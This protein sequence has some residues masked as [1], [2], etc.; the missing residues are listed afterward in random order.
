MRCCGPAGK[1]GEFMFMAVEARDG[2]GKA[3]TKVRQGE[4]GLGEAGHGLAGQGPR[5]GEAWLG[6]AGQGRARIMGL[7]DC[8]LAK[9]KKQGR[10]NMQTYDVRLEGITPLLMHSDDIQWAD[11][12][13]AWRMEPENKKSGT[14]GDDRSPAWRWIGALYED[15][16]KV[17]IPSDNLMTMLREGGAKCPTGKGKTT[18]KAITQTGLVVDQ[19]AWPIEVRGEHV[20]YAPIKAMIGEPLFEEH[21]KLAHDL[22][23]FLF[24][25]RA[26][27][28][29]SKHIRVR[30][31]FDQW[32][33]AGT[34]TVTDGQITERMLTSILTTAGAHVGIGDWR[35]SSKK[36]PGR[37]GRFTVTVRRAGK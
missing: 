8:P 25:K 22:G 15:A 5:R 12:M 2:G 21:E 20:P 35:P 24:V 7:P 3:G 27:V 11:R 37:Y 33:A 17:V 36:S 19:F 9:R 31:R 26:K 32:A 28:G 16:G 13:A 30:P 23:F 29:D 18:F 14:A 10:A 34:V 4:A 1:R 6:S